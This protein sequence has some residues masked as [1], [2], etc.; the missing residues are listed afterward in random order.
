MVKGEEQ[1]LNWSEH[2][3]LSQV[4]CGRRSSSEESDPLVLYFGVGDPHTSAIQGY[5]FIIILL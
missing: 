1:M 5:L 4:S 3:F 2:P